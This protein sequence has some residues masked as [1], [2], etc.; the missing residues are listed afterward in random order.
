MKID[1]KKVDKTSP[2]AAVSSSFP[3]RHSMKKAIVCNVLS[4][5]VLRALIFNRRCRVSAKNTFP[6]FDNLELTLKANLFSNLTGVGE[7][8]Q[9]RAKE[10]LV[11]RGR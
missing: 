7:A 1:T 6:S 8:E 2:K 4:L 3:L 11:A 9:A 5:K 10:W